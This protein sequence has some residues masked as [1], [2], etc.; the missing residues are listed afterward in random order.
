MELVTKT[1]GS[2]NMGVEALV[3]VLNHFSAILGNSSGATKILAWVGIALVTIVVIYYVAIGFIKLLKVFWRMN[4]KYL[5]L[6]LFMLGVV[7][8]AISLILP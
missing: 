3:E 4:V 5:G 1:F 6:V 2:I 8:I 7:F